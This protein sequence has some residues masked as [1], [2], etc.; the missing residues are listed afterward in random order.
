[1]TLFLLGLILLAP[2]EPPPPPSPCSTAWMGKAG[3]ADI[4]CAAE[5]GANWS[6][7]FAYPLAVSRVPAL[8]REFAARREL[9]RRD[10]DSVEA[11]AAAHPDSRFFHEEVFRADANRPELIA[12]SSLTSQYAGGAHPWYAADTL[13]WDR[14]ANREIGLY[15]L[16]DE[17]AAARAELERQLCPALV[18]VRRRYFEE[19]GGRFDGGCEGPPD[20][21]ALAAGEDGRIDTLRVRYAELDG[22]AGGEYEVF[23][24]VTPLLIEAMKQ[25]FRPAFR[26]STAPALGCNTNL[27]EPAC[28]VRQRQ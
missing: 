3:I 21:A 13:I 23:V 11:Y 26:L 17:P 9:S 24:P 28:R 22:Y 2:S 8:E 4:R 7:A 1:M 20:E 15:D 18:S 16:F 19:R 25:R 12:L 6:F 5:S 14:A 10:F 27:V